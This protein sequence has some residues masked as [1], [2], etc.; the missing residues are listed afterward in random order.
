M[1]KLDDDKVA[2]I[3]KSKSEGSLTNGDI[4]DAISISINRVQQLYIE[5]KRSNSVPK[6]KRAGRKRKDIIEEERNVVRKLYGIYK[7]NACYLE[8]ILSA[9]GYYD[10]NYNRIHK[11]LVQEGLALTEEGK[12]VRR[13]KWI[14]YEREFS[15]SLWHIR[16]IKT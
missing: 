13:K 7:A 11:I 8:K 2:W 16:Y 12:H 6:L 1:A 10:I 9:H 14:R 15:N 5:Y 4:A 3:I